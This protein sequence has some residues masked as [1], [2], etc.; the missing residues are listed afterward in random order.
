MELAEGKREAGKERETD[1]RKKGKNKE[2]VE[3]LLQARNC[4][5]VCVWG[6]GSSMFIL[7]TPQPWRT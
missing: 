3:L 6:G 2:N 5:Y 4:V 1:G 7:S